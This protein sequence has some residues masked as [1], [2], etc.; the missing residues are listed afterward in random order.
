MEAPLDSVP[1]LDPKAQ[2]PDK[3][4][5]SSRYTQAE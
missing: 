2:N 4:G 5:R 3:S 1:L